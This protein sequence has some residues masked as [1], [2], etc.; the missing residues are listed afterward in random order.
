[1]TEENRYTT[2]SIHRTTHAAL[3]YH[4]RKSETFDQGIRR[5]IAESNELELM[6]LMQERG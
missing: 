3:V 4:L 1:M 6:K 5:L 2:I